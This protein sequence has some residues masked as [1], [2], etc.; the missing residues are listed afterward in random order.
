MAWA[1]IGKPGSANGPCRA[2]QHIDC[3]GA[4]EM[5]ARICQSCGR[6]LDYGEK[7]TEMDGQLVHFVCAIKATN[8]PAGA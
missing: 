4:R 8:A 2:C 1:I 6:R 5:A 3:Q 7:Y